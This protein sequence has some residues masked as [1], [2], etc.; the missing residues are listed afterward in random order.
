MPVTACGRN[1]ARVR[2][3]VPPD[4]PIATADYNDPESLE[5]AFV[6]VKK[7]LFVA[8]DG[9]AED[10]LRQHANVIAAADR[11]SIE[12]VVFTSIIDVEESSPFYSP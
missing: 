9:F 8:S 7:L 11:S 4:T 2:Q 3:A 12:H 6:K 10:V 5:R 1:G